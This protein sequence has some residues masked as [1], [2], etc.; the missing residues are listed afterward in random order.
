MIVDSSTASVSLTEESPTWPPDQIRVLEL[1]FELW[2]YMH[3]P[4]YWRT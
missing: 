3:L 4:G 1:W 2:F